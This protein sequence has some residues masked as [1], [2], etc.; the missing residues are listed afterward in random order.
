MSVEVSIGYKS[1]DSWEN[2][3]VYVCKD[4]SVMRWQLSLLSNNWEQWVTSE[5]TVEKWCGDSAKARS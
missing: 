1:T 3:Y 4:D 5:L 2:G